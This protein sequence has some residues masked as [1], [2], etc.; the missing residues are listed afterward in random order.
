VIKL[1]GSYPVTI[2]PA[3]PFIKQGDLQMSTPSSRSF[4]DLFSAAWSTFRHN[5]GLCLGITIIFLVIYLVVTVTNVAV[6]AMMLSDESTVAFNIGVGAVTSI[7]I[8]GV[9]IFPLAAY[10]GFWLVQ[11]TRG[12]ERS[13]RGR[14]GTL[15]VIGILTQ[16]CFLPGQ[17]VHEYSNPGAMEQLRMA[18]EMIGAG[19][20][21]G[22]AKGI[23]DNV[24]KKDVDEHGGKLEKDSPNAAE[25]HAI[26]DPLAKSYDEANARM[27]K[28]QEK[29]QELGNERNPMMMLFAF[30]LILAAL[31]FTYFW[32]PW[33]MYAAL[34]P[35]EKSSNTGA[36]LARGRELARNASVVDIWLVP[37]VF[38]IIMIGTVAM[39]CLPGVFF[40][41]PL[42][43]AVVPGMYMCLRGERGDEG[44]TAPT[45]VK[46]KGVR[47]PA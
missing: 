20:Q 31:I 46:D 32:S 36:A 25:R 17:A 3:S 15:V 24:V 4:G 2:A 35:L 43:C 7:V 42:A 45:V 29:M 1:Q 34:D 6:L 9:F 37:F 23:L 28:L 22:I 30:L 18:P 33:S 5:Y 16:L 13:Q 39:C 19:F 12:G 41:L 11:R 26:I 10:M 44:E 21:K 47:V 27:N 38:I 8:S 14:Y 40:G